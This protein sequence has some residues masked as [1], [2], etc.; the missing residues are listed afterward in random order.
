MTDLAP[1][2]NPQTQSVVGFWRTTR[3]H[4]SL[5]NPLVMGIVNATPDSFSSPG[6]PFSIAEVIHTAEILLREGADVLDIGGESTRPGAVPLTH[7]QEWHRVEPVLRELITWKVPVSVDT[8]HPENMQKS[9]D[10]GVD[11]INDV[12][13]LRQANALDVVAKYDC[14]VCLMH[15]HDNPTTMQLSPM[16]EET[17]EPVFEFL[18]TQTQFVQ[19]HGVA[20]DRIVVD[21]GIGFGKT[22]TQNFDIL[23]R[24]KLLLELGFPVMVGWSRKSSL[25]KVTGLDVADRCVPSVAAAILAIER[26]AKIVRVHDVAQTVSALAV[27]KNAPAFM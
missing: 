3:F 19:L 6:T 7:E 18:Q 4:I 15:M 17:L 16:Q 20:A 10:L 12:W 26:G 25:G 27:W 23:Q 9:L 24:Q 22:V 21:P 11:I 8:Y 1:K 5:Q 13:A 2:T 14:G